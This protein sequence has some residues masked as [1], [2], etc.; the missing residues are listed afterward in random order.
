MNTWPNCGNVAFLSDAEGSL[1]AGVI[2][3]HVAPELK[4]QL[5]AEMEN[6]GLPLF[7]IAA[8]KAADAMA[9]S[10]RLIENEGDYILNLTEA[11]ER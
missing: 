1:C 8:E 7:S 3:D 5:G 6:L 10:I 4:K 11:S 9:E 2:T